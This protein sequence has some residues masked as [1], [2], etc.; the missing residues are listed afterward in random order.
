[1]LKIIANKPLPKNNQVSCGQFY[2]RADVDDVYFVTHIYCDGGGGDYYVLINLRYGVS[3][4]MA[5]SNINDIF[6][7]HKD[8]FFLVEDVTITLNH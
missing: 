3:Y 8:K 2:Q 1:M 6:G 4:N 7:N 5:T